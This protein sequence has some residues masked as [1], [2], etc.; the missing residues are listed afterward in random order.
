MCVSLSTLATTEPIC[1]VF[2]RNFVSVCKP[3]DPSYDR[4]GALVPTSTIHEPRTLEPRYEACEGALGSGERRS[5][6]GSA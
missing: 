2:D 3:L 6:G 1:N 4:A 5:G